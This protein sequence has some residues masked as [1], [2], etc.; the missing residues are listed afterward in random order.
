MIEIYSIYSDSTILYSKRFFHPGLTF[1]AHDLAPL[2][3]QGRF[4]KSAPASS[5]SPQSGLGKTGGAGAF[6]GAFSGVSGWRWPWRR[7]QKRW[8]TD[9]LSSYDVEVWQVWC[10]ILF[11]A[12]PSEIIRN[13]SPDRGK[14]LRHRHDTRRHVC[15]GLPGNVDRSFLP[16]QGRSWDLLNNLL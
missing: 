8:H 1:I 16:W 12:E 13:S 9:L 7:H 5:G 11:H 10:A 14:F 3:R 15:T 4:A 6:S 2:H